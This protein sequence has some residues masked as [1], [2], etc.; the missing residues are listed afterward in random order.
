MTSKQ[1]K[2]IACTNEVFIEQQRSF[3]MFQWFLARA[4]HLQRKM[5]EALHCWSV[6]MKFNFT[7]LVV[8]KINTYCGLIK[9]RRK[10]YF[11]KLICF[12]F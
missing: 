11:I 2:K 3:A 5:N 10:N 9:V 4:D 1:S 7:L 6:R 8:Y 12:F